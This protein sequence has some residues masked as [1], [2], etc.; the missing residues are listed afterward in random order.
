MS[1][2]KLRRA[3]AHLVWLRAQY[4]TEHCWRPEGPL[5]SPPL[6]AMTGA[7]YACLEAIDRLWN[8]L[9]YADHPAQIIRAIALVALEMQDSTRALAREVIPHSKDWSDRAR[10]WPQ[11]EAAMREFVG[12][13]HRDGFGLDGPDTV[14]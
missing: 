3:D 1:R 9:N 7:D 8:A 11:V 6:G 10:Y 2:A 5:V 13:A 14:P 4:K 12:E